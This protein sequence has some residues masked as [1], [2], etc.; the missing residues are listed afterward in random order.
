MGELSLLLAAWPFTAAA[1]AECAPTYSQYCCRIHRLFIL[2]YI[3]RNSSWCCFLFF[4][5]TLFILSGRQQGSVCLRFKAAVPFVIVRAFVGLGVT[6]STGHLCD[7][8][9]SP[10]NTRPRISWLFGCTRSLVV[11]AAGTVSCCYNSCCKLRACLMCECVCVALTAGHSLACAT[12]HVT[13]DLSRTTKYALIEEN[14]IYHRQ[15]CCFSGRFFL[16]LNVY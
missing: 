1:D 5:V 3:E 2:V 9:L 6:P 12:A 14:T 11:K 16:A 15:F 13:I 8:T 7:A 10:P 4:L